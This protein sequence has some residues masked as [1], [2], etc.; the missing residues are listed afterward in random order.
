MANE[1]GNIGVF[2][3]LFTA[4]GDLAQQ[5]TNMAG[6]AVKTATDTVQPVTNACVQLCTTTINSAT[7]IVEGVTK[8]ITTALAP[9]Q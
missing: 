4:V 6:S 8:A 7:Q 3:D 1:S 5:S 9:K 2:G